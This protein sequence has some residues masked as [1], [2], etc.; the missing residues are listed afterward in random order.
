[1]DPYKILR[2]S[3]TDSLE[4]IRN[5]F[6]KVARNVH[7]DKGGTEEMFNVVVESYRE[8]FKLKKMQ[9]EEE[10]S[11]QQ[12]KEESKKHNE[13]Q[14]GQ[15][16]V[17][18]QEDKVEFNEEL[19]T[20][21]NRVFDDNRLG[22][23]TDDGYGGMMAS[24]S[25]AREDIYIE[26]IV[27]NEKD[28]HTSF[29]RQKSLNSDLVKYKEPEALCVQSKKLT[30]D[31]LGVGNIDDFSSDTVGKQLMYMDYMKA[32]TTNKLV[33]KELIRKQGT[34]KNLEDIT[35]QRLKQSFELTDE[36]KR[37]IEEHEQQAKLKEVSRKKIM[38]EQDTMAQSNF[39]KVNKLM[40]R[41]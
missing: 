22:N 12:M 37:I 10:A 35:K 23:V 15:R 13:K 19:Q 21:F 25:S 18:F 8:I 3:K 31:E 11:F 27:Q 32:H 4:H 36:D 26:R 39:A 5:A 20:K 17:H 28:L 29:D 16:S 1:M 6:K 9:E 2:V 30:Y 41:Q 24:S 38:E 40:L 34:Y 33:D 14:N 7:P